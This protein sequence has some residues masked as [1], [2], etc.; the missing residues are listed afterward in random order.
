ML[1]SS[2]VKNLTGPDLSFIRKG[3]HL[4]KYLHGNSSNESTLDWVVILLPY[5]IVGKDIIKANKDRSFQN[6]QM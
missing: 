4:V 6:N 1:D 3:Y 2:E 5:D